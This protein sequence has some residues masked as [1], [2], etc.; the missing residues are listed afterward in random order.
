MPQ[1]KCS[2]SNP[3]LKSLTCALSDR[4]N[5]K[6]VPPPEPCKKCLRTLF[7]GQHYVVSVW[8]KFP[9]PHPVCDY[10]GRFAFAYVSVLADQCLGN[11]QKRFWP[12]SGASTSF[13]H[14]EHRLQYLKQ[15]Q[16]PSIYF[17]GRSHMAA[18]DEDYAITLYIPKDVKS[19]KNAFVL[20]I[21]DDL[22]AFTIETLD[23]PEFVLYKYKFV[24][25]E[26]QTNVAYCTTS[27]STEVVNIHSDYFGRYSIEYLTSDQ[28]VACSGLL[29]TLTYPTTLENI[30]DNWAKHVGSKK[31][32]EIKKE[33]SGR[34]SRN[35]CVVI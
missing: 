17:L 23:N 3:S 31:I 11:G 34:K 27:L 6:Q 19:G 18:I 21:H 12:R 5:N 2:F 20:M 16:T 25:N 35:K 9:A 15:C 26:E 10:Q 33:L 1:Q 4:M 8:G 32:E 13:L 29:S 30:L 7:S 14:V 28:L 22:H 24:L